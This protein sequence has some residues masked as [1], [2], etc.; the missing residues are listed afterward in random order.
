M[1]DGRKVMAKNS[2][3]SFG[4][5]KQQLECSQTVVDFL[6]SIKTLPTRNTIVVWG[7]SNI[8]IL[9]TRNTTV[10]WGA[11]VLFVFVLCFVFPNIADVS[12]LSIFVCPFGY[13]K[14]LYNLAP[15]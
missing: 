13:L 2:H 5:L 10:L 15:S 7:E 8:K 12:G 1:Y 11:F 6:F 14:L 3:A 9:P 4:V